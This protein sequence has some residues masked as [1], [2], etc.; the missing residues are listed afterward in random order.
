MNFN[1]KAKDWDL[2]PR[3]IER[4]KAIAEAIQKGLPLNPE[5]SGLE[6]GCGTGLLS[7]HLQPLL[8]TIHLADTSEGMLEVLQEKMTVAKVKNMV[9]MKLDL[10]TEPLPDLRFDLIY[11]Q[12]TLHH[13]DDTEKILSLFHQLLKKSGYLC[14]ADLDKEDG[15][16]HEDEFHG[17]HGFKR[18]DFKEN[19][20]NQKFGNIQFS[21]VYKVTKEIKG[22][23]KIFPVFL[24]IAQKAA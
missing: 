10:M 17:H 24:V 14:I 1:E 13:I 5:W 12:M 19:L 2:K 21:T 6:Y 9:P 3:N 11:S 15:S 7:F 4:S 23:K 18:K 20:L 8:K 16:F 22:K